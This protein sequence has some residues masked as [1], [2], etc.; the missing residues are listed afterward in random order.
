MLALPA[1]RKSTVRN[2][3]KSTERMEE[4]HDRQSTPESNRERS[5]STFES[6]TESPSRTC[7]RRYGRADG[8]TEETGQTR[9]SQRTIRSR[10]GTDEGMDAADCEAKTQRE[11]A[12]DNRS[13]KF[14]WL[15]SDGEIQ[16]TDLENNPRSVGVEWRE[17]GDQVGRPGVFSPPG[18]VQGNAKMGALSRQ[19]R[20]VSGKSHAVW[21]GSKPI[22]GEQ[23]CQSVASSLEQ[24]KDQ[25]PVVRG[26]RTGVGRHGTAVCREDERSPADPGQF[27]RPVE[28]REMRVGTQ[29]TSRIPGN[30][31][32]P[33]E[34]LHRSIDEQ[35][36]RRLQGSDEVEA[37]RID[38]C[39]ASGESGRQIGIFTSWYAERHWIGEAIDVRSRQVGGKTRMD[40]NHDEERQGARPFENHSTSLENNNPESDQQTLETEKQP[41]HRRVGFWVG[42]SPGRT[43]DEENQPR[44]VFQ[45]RSERTHHTERSVC[46]RV[47]SAKF[48]SEDPRP[49]SPR[50]LDGL[51]SNSSRVEERVSQREIDEGSN[52]NDSSPGET[53]NFDVNTMDSGRKEYESRQIVT[54]V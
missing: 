42:S 11:V 31:H 53:R 14:E 24:E 22:L 45:T 47:G 28:Q 20:E 40:E 33:E 39:N 19:R 2:G 43:Q 52:R 17:V 25:P 29:R 21:A 1:A 49:K 10:S 48:E 32:R 36:E 44:A 9:C 41:D 30:E 35:V 23:V 8:R 12:D 4:K 38:V 27:G 5:S 34:R 15:F 18:V 50:G 46:H 54:E 16:T 51:H 13:E 37:R 7:A 6:E 3:P 26:R